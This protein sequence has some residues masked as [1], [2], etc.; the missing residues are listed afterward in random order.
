MPLSL[1]RGIPWLGIQAAAQPSGD[2]ASCAF[3]CLG[4]GC[5]GARRV[6]KKPVRVGGAWPEWAR[7]ACGAKFRLG[8][9]R[10]L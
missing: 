4:S 7:E 2:V 6:S 1:N 10:A 3:A 5:A 9:C 8:S